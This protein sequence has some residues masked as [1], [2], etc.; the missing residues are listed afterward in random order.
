[1]RL[2]YDI[3]A[4]LAAAAVLWLLVSLSAFVLVF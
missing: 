2:A 4:M 1:M 3:L